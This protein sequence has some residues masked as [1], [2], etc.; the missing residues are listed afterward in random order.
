MN[1]VRTNDT[2]NNWKIL[3]GVGNFNEENNTL[4][5]ALGMPDDINNFYEFRAARRSRNRHFIISCGT[6]DKQHR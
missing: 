5:N 6:Q 4:A 1:K 3:R 2:N